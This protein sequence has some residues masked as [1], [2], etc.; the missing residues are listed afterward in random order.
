MR[1]AKILKYITARLNEL[2]GKTTAVD[3]DEKL[4]TNKVVPSDDPEDLTQAWTDKKDEPQT[5]DR[6][7]DGDLFKQFLR[8]DSINPKGKL[9][10]LLDDNLVD[11]ITENVVARHDVVVEERAQFT[12]KDVLR[13]LE[14][15]ELFSSEEHDLPLGTTAKGKLLKGES[16]LKVSDAY[17]K[18]ESA[19]GPNPSLLL[20]RI[21]GLEGEMSTMRSFM[22]DMN[23]SLNQK[24]SMIAKGLKVEEDSVIGK[25]SLSEESFD[26]VKN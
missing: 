10:H 23:K 25:P 2:D 5:L 21:E 15:E 20:R 7:V 13:L 12:A 1:D 17:A 19:S 24:L 6:T 26:G 8:P 22:H 18:R 4:K 11:A 9:E 3:D 16:S 14:V